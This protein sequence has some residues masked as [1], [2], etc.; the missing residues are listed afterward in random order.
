MEDIIKLLKTSG[1][2]LAAGL[3]VLIVGVIAVHFVTKAVRRRIE[4]NEKLK[5]EPTV[6]SFLSNVARIALY[7][8]VILTA[9]HIMGIPMTSV[10]AL[11][12]SAGVAVSLAMQG[13]LG[14]LVGGVMIVLLRPIA[15]G[16]Y[17]S[18]AG[19]EGTVQGIGVFYTDVVTFDG[20]HVSIPNSSLTNTPITNFTREGRRRAEVVFALSYDSP[21]DEVFRVLTELTDRTP[22][23]LKDPAPS[24]HLIACADSSMN[25]AV[26][27]WAKNEDYWDVYFALMEDGKRALDA[28]GIQIPYPQMDVHVK[29]DG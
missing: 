29:N 13:A 8:L 27:V 6:R 11:L 3:A 19:C 10:V 28:A 23:I 2:K 24:V 16:E 15:V 12:A 5:M 4:Q 25:Y 14:N 21:M 1:V 20:K 7:L 18:A 26:R 9:I 17:I 22:G